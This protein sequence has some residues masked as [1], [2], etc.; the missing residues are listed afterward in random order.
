MCDENIPHALRG[1]LK[2][3]DVV[4]AA[5][6]GFAGLKNGKLLDAAE[7]AGFEIL[8]TGDKTLHREQNLAARKIAVV[9]ISANSWTVIGPY[10]DRIVAAVDRAA[11]GS[12]VRVDC[13]V[14]TRRRSGPAGPAVV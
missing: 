7:T 12:F 13:G 1:H 6:A 3:H 14:F 9:S 8:I 11:P 10:A 4:T 2:H 5:Y